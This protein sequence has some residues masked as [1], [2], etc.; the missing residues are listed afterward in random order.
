MHSFINDDKNILQINEAI[1]ATTEDHGADTDVNQLISLSLD[2]GLEQGP[3]QPAKKRDLRTHKKFR[4]F[5]LES[6]KKINMREEGRSENECRR[7]Q[8]QAIKSQLQSCD[9]DQILAY[10]PKKAA[11]KQAQPF[12]DLG[13]KMGSK[14][15]IF[16]NFLA[17]LFT[18]NI[19]IKKMGLG[20]SGMPLDKSLMLQTAK[21]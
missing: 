12:M 8:S 3:M 9:Q 4:E 2:S 10:V 11:L 16:D 20:G 18:N 7:I 17:D 5:I 19:D 15:D 13:L 14:E 6:D 1:R 21:K